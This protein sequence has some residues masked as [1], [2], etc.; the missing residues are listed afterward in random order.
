M[1]SLGGPL[2]RPQ[3]ERCDR[4]DR[5]AVG[6]HR[7]FYDVEKLL[8]LAGELVRE[9]DSDGGELG[10]QPLHVSGIATEQA[11]FVDAS[12]HGPA[13]TFGLS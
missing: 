9:D 13:G 5:S 11:D 6:Q 7:C 8:D 2:C 12:A 10:R 1:G 4:L 3:R